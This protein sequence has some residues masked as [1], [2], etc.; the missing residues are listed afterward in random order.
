[1][2]GSSVA[3]P[4]SEGIYL[5]FGASSAAVLTTVFL[6]ANPGV[7]MNS[8]DNMIGIEGTYL[9]IF[10]SVAHPDGGL[11]ATMWGD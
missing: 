10:T 3:T 9:A 4:S 7:G 5:R 11:V 2:S 1:M 6:C 8:A